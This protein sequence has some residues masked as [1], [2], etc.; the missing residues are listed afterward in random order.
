MTTLP[1]GLVVDPVT[2]ELVT[3]EHLAAVYAD[4]AEALAEHDAERQRLR[5]Q[6]ERLRAALERIDGLSLA[7]PEARVA[8]DA[9]ASDD[10]AGTA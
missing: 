4:A 9:L 1:D 3:P 7:L 6:V 5:E 2:G 10:E 8:R